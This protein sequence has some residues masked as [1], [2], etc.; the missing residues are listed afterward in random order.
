MDGDGAPVLGGVRGGQHR[1]LPVLGRDARLGPA[2]GAGAAR[3]CFGSAG[4]GGETSTSAENFADDRDG[5]FE[6]SDTAL[7]RKH[8]RPRL[9][10][11]DP[12]VY[13]A[14]VVA[15]AALRLS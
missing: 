10:Y 13:F 6:R 11:G 15:N 14:A 3:E 8:L 2:P 12:N 9:L 1:V 4:A 7:Q 5:R